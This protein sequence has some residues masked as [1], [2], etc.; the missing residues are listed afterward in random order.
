MMLPIRWPVSDDPRIAFGD[1]DEEKHPRDEKGRFAV[2]AEGPSGF[3][4]DAGASHTLKGT[5]GTPDVTL[6]RYGVWQQ[7]SRGRHEVVHVTDDLDE[8]RS[9]VGLE[10]H[11]KAESDEGLKPA[12]ALPPPSSR[13]GLKPE[14]SDDFSAVRSQAQQDALNTARAR[15]KEEQ[16]A[17]AKTQ[18]GTRDH[19]FARAEL[20]H[21][22]DLTKRLDAAF[23]AKQN[24]A[25]AKSSGA[26]K[27]TI[28][29][30]RDEA[31]RADEAV[32]RARTQKP[33]KS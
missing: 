11:Q 23:R 1:W 25:I 24:L 16:G 26:S 9:R 29:R 33:Q 5:G 15:V 31:W 13:G 12:K 22:Q 19:E 17:V 18:P 3:V 7:T 6:P 14:G 8:A 32:R 4:T 27:A 28:A 2:V 30:R 10:P 20:K 21:Q